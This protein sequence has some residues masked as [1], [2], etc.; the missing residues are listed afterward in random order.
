MIEVLIAL[1][2]LSVGILA[3]L[4]MQISG[5]QAN[6]DAVQRTAASH[7]A[8]D[9]IE[10]MRANAVARDEY[11]TGAILGDDSLAAPN[12]TC[13]AA[14]SSCTPTQMAAADLY[15]WERAVDGQSEV[16]DIGGV[17]VATGGLVQPRACIDVS[18]GGTSGAFVLVLV[19]RGAGAL[20]PADIEECGGNLNGTNL[21]GSPDDL[22]SDQ[23]R[24]VA[25]FP[26]FI[27]G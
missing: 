7:L 21:Y 19:W 26:F 17:D 27:G 16:R 10:R 15:Q 20:E 3:I 24:R 6:Y 23:F 22:D 8:A 25:R 13:A 2:V 11:V 9:L 18:P 4:G 12:P 1:V 14:G 5:K